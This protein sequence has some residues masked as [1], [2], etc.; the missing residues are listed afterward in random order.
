MGWF[1][2]VNTMQD[3]PKSKK[4]PFENV[5]QLPDFGPTRRKDP[6]SELFTHWEE[7][8]GRREAPR[9]AEVDPREIKA[10]LN[11]TFIVE[12]TRFGGSRFRVTGAEVCDLMGMELRGMQITALFHP[13]HR[14]ELSATLKD[15]YATASVY[16]YELS[17][18][19]AGYRQVNAKLLLLP[20]RDDQD[21]ITRI[22]GG[23]RLDRELLRPPVRFEI[24]NSVKNRI[25]SD[26]SLPQDQP[27]LTAFAEDTE[28]FTH[29][30]TDPEGPRIR[31]VVDND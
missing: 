3:V 12:R 19:Q 29:K 14:R 22:L 31:L 23:I 16:E 17:T 9:R 18:F 24:V 11:H 7:L 10:A 15:I 27:F 6:L 26:T 30:P 21:R 2:W 20:L 13:D 4:S 28:E 1:A 25:I 5:V 8:R